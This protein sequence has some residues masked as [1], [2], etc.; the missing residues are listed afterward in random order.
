[1]FRKSSSTIFIISCLFILPILSYILRLFCMSKSICLFQETTTLTD[2]E[3][4][5]RCMIYFV[6]RCSRDIFWEASELCSARYIRPRERAMIRRVSSAVGINFELP[7]GRSSVK[8]YAPESPASTRNCHCDTTSV[9]SFINF[10]ESSAI[11]TNH[12]RAASETVV[13]SLTG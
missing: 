7:R 12:R 13:N 4:V 9:T 2:F 10:M 11:S 5:E 8:H 3:F 1:M 6:H